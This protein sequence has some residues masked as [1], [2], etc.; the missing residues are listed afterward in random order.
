MYAN[1]YYVLRPFQ[2]TNP[3]LIVASLVINISTS[4]HLMY[5]ASIRFA[6]YRQICHFFFGFGG[7]KLS[8]LIS[9]SPP[10]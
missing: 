8:W 1:H 5:P 3:S 9:C 6:T 2:V 10:L 4:N 7:T